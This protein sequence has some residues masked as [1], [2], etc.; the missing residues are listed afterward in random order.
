V[1]PTASGVLVYS[2]AGD[3]WRDCRDYVHARLGLPTWRPGNQSHHVTVGW[4]DPEPERWRTER[5]KAIWDE[6]QDPRGTAAE[7][8]FAARKLHLPLELCGSVMRFHPQCPWK[9]DVKFTSIPCLIAAFTS[10]ADNTITAIHRIRL[11]RPERWPKTERKM[12]GAVA[13]SA[14]K[15]DPPGQRLAIAEGIESALAARQLGF[16]AVWALGSARR[17]LPVDGV[18]ELIILGERDD[19]SR[20]ATDVCSESWIARGMT[21]HLALPAIGKDFNDYVMG[22]G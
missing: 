21:V 4:T 5:V 18:R 1:K 14:V 7:E 22:A 3:D 20:R 6:G 9:S 13:G 8:Y 17:F 2:H 10:I 12:F 15:L 11:D 16:G 19:A